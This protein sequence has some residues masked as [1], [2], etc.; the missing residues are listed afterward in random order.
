MSTTCCHSSCVASAR[1]FPPEACF[2]AERHL[3]TASRWCTRDLNAPQAN[4]ARRPK[5]EAVIDH[6]CYTIAEPRHHT[7]A[8]PR[9]MHVGVQFGLALVIDRQ[10]AEARSLA[11]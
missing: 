1:R 2:K 10:T 3:K 4:G 5:S 6:I 8:P 9:R 7:A 11:G